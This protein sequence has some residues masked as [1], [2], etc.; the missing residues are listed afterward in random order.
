MWGVPGTR[1][2]PDIYYF[3]YLVCGAAF[4]LMAAISECVAGLRGTK[5]AR[6]ARRLGYRK[7]SS[8]SESAIRVLSVSCGAKTLPGDSALVANVTRYLEHHIAGAPAEF[9]EETGLAHPILVEYTFNGEPYLVALNF[10]AGVAGDPPVASRGCKILYSTKET[11]W[12][13]V[14]ITGEMERVHGP[15]RDFHGGVPGSV[16]DLG[17]FFGTHGTVVTFDG[18]YKKYVLHQ[19]DPAPGENVD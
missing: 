14:D 3:G 5:S 6:P 10:L 8:D 15:G 1:A 18:S 11:R 13:T 4:A 7:T 2:V 9:S 16:Q 12:G 17:F 19:E